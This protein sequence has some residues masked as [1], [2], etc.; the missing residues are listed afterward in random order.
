MSR[1]AQRIEPWGHS[2]GQDH[3]FD[4]RLGRRSLLAFL[5]GAALGVAIHAY[6][7]LRDFR[8]PG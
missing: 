8:V 5:V 4:W 3:D 6:L 2:G 1:K 7:W